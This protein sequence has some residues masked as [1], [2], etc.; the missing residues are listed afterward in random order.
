ML[1]S[2]P[3]SC[4]VPLGPSAMIPPC[5]SHFLWGGVSQGERWEGAKKRQKWASVAD[6]WGMDPVAALTSRPSPRVPLG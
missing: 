2:G 1:Q 3:P 5:G 4:E 6:G